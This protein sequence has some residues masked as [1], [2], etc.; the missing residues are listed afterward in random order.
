MY[1][2]SFQSFFHC[3]LTH[4]LILPIKMPPIFTQRHVSLCIDSNFKLVTWKLQFGACDL[5]TESV[6]FF[7]NLGTSSI[8]LPPSRSLSSSKKIQIHKSISDVAC[9][10][11]LLIAQRLLDLNEVYSFSICCLIWLACYFKSFCSS[12]I[13]SQSLLSFK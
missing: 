8:F 6:L 4:L 1:F 10:D 9:T 3:R 2:C 7:S 11:F 13:I 5:R 12:L